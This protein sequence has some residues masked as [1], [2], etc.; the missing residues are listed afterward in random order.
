MASSE[1]LYEEKFPIILDD[2][3][4][5]Y[6]D[7]RLARILEWLSGQ[8]C[9]IILFTCQKREVELLED[10]GIEYHYVNLSE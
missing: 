3:F 1:I 6:D 2:A 8:G 10:L 5:Y 7:I 4:A 9:Q